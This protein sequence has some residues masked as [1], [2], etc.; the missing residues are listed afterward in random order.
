MNR[1]T[2]LQKHKFRTNMDFNVKNEFEQEEDNKH[3]SDSNH[4]L[5]PNNQ[6]GVDEGKMQK[7]SESAKK[8]TPTEKARH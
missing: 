8:F 7:N 5:Q 4:S 3:S 2:S 1:K 6:A